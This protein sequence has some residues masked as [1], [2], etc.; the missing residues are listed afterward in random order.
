LPAMSCWVMVPLQFWACFMHVRRGVLRDDRYRVTAVSVEH[1]DGVE[2]DDA[3]GTPTM[4]ITRMPITCSGA[5]LNLICNGDFS[6]G[7][8][9]FSSAMTFNGKLYH[10]RLLLH[11]TLFR[12]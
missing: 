11:W 9:G 4:S 7:N 2:H 5:N 8:V 1:D 3:F 12:F 10:T 6:Q